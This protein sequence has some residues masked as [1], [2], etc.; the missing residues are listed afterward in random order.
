MRRAIAP[1]GRNTVTGLFDLG[2]GS[3]C[4]YWLGLAKLEFM[5][6]NGLLLLSEKR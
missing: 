1:D 3:G 6:Y 2:R 5:P 4:F